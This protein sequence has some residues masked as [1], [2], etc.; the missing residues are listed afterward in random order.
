MVGGVA[1]WLLGGTCGLLGGSCGRPEP[2]WCDAE[3]ALEMT[4]EL[5]LVGEAGA[6]GDIRQGYVRSGLQELLGPLDA[7]KDDGLMRGSP[8]A[9]SSSRL[10]RRPTR[11]ADWRLEAR[12]RGLQCGV[13][14]PC[15]RCQGRGREVV[16]A[17]EEHPD[18][19]EQQLLERH[20]QPR[21]PHRVSGPGG[22]NWLRS[23]TPLLIGGIAIRAA[24]G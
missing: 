6:Q 9:G 22:G 3:E 1:S 2:P 14:L 13:Q 5:A 24:V 20:R 7:A 21:L 11:S 23:I 15:R 10:N 4:G 12:P 17:K 16:A 18:V 8:V 19:L